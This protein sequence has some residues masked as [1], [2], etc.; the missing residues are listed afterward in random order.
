MLRSG[1]AERY[2]KHAG[3][4]PVYLPAYVWAKAVSAR[5]F[6]VSVQPSRQLEHD[7]VVVYPYG[8]FLEAM[9]EEKLFV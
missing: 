6:G 8:Q 9:W 7:R 3:I 2:G 1:A 4:F 5:G